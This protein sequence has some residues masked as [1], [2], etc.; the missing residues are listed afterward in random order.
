VDLETFKSEY[1]VSL[2]HWLTAEHMLVV[3]ERKFNCE[4]F[5]LCLNN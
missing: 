3:S 2:F 4:R 5:M 1:D